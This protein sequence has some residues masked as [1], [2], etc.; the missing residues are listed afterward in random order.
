MIKLETAHIEEVRGIRKLDIN[1]QKGTF[2]SQ[3]GGRAAFHHSRRSWS[4]RGDSITSRS[5]CPLPC[6]TLSIMRPLS[7]SDTFRFATS[8]TRRPAP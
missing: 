2:V 3:T 5:R 7:M 8:D 1:F 6:S 4:S